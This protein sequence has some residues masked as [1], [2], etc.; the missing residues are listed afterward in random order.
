MAIPGPELKPL[1]FR[2]CNRDVAT[3]WVG[4]LHNELIGLTFNHDPW[5]QTCPAFQ[6]VQRP[7][8][9]L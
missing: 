2:G 9:G 3:D 4:L 8:G 1:M 7:G 5:S 6:A